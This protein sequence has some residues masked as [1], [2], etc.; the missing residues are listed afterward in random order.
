MMHGDG[1]LYYSN[2]N[3]YE[4]SFLNGKKFGNGSFFWKSTGVIYKGKWNDDKIHGEG[5]LKNHD[6]SVRKLRYYHGEIVKN[7]NPRRNEEMGDNG[8]KFDN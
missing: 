6:G 5:E 8:F 7:Y 3:L 1:K 2:G 4:G